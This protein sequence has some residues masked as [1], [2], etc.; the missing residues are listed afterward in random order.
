MDSKLVLMHLTS[1]YLSADSNLSEII[2]IMI[3]ISTSNPMATRE[4][5]DKFPEEIYKIQ[6][7]P[8]AAREI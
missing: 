2:H 8:S 6:N 3:I 4:I 7:F 5:W 1:D